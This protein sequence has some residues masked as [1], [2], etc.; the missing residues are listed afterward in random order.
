MNKPLRDKNGNII[1]CGCDYGKCGHV[2]TKYLIEPLKEAPLCQ[3][4]YYIYNNN[5][6]KYYYYYGINGKGIISTIMY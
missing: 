6:D 4:H 2:A 3:Y 5:T 1:M